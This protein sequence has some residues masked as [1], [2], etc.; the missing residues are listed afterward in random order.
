MSSE[1]KNGDGKKYSPT[2]TTPDSAVKPPQASSLA[3]KPIS[4]NESE[5]A[6]ILLNSIPLPADTVPHTPLKPPPSQI[7]PSRHVPPLT[8]SMNYDV[9][10]P[11]VDLP[12]LQIPP[13][14]QPYDPTAAYSPTAP[15]GY[16]PH[17]SMG[18]PSTP[19]MMSPPP[20][21]YPSPLPPATSPHVYN[22][23]FSY[24]GPRF[25]TRP[26]NSAYYDQSYSK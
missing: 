14:H 23:N 22:N 20:G 2:K 24:R 5:E 15:N 16:Y 26:L 13:P 1:I 18:Y 6:N 8:M 17:P 3:V 10:P 19:R 7:S 9:A 4:A 25:P 21:Y 12:T 11:G